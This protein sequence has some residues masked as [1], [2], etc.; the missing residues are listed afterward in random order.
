MINVALDDNNL[1]EKL[2]MFIKNR[3]PVEEAVKA[4]A[5]KTREVAIEFTPTD[6]WYGKYQYPERKSHELGYLK[7]HWKPPSYSYTPTGYQAEVVN[8]AEY[9]AAANFGHSAHVGQYIPPLPGRVTVD[10]VGGLFITDA[11]EHMITTEY[12][13]LFS[14]KYGA[15]LTRYLK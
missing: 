8:D 14:E 3:K 15:Y 12:S 6:R 4:V 9:A 2:L 5:E 13:N 1:A 11:V 10:W 7:K